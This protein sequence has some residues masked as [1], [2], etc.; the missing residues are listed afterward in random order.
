MSARRVDPVRPD[1]SEDDIAEV[2]AAVAAALRSGQLAQGAQVEAFEAEMA[3]LVDSRHAVAVASGTA[4]LVC[5]LRSLSDGARGEVL[6]PANAFYSSAAAPLLAGLDTRLAEIDLDTLAPTLATLEA[7]ATERTVGVL[8]V[9]MGGII[10]PEVT[11]IAEWCDRHGLWLVEDCAHAH[12]SRLGGR[13][14]GRFGVAGAFSFF[15][16]KVITSGEGGMVVTDDDELAHLVRLHRNLGKPEPWRSVHTVLG[17]N[18]RMS[19]LHAAVGRTQL[20]RLGEFVETRT[21]LA[22][23][24]TKA[25]QG[26][27]GVRPLLPPHDPA[28]WYKYVL[29]LDPA[30]DRAALSAELE[31]RGVRLGGAIY[32]IPLHHQPVLRGWLPAGRYPVAEAACARH[33]CLPLHTR[34]TDDDVDF[35]VAALAQ[36][37]EA[38]AVPEGEGDADVVR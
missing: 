33:V 9:H 35:V 23:R 3:E 25:L 16:T 29:L 32:E 6:V 21:R 12:G 1:F 34:M 20:R 5:V 11:A 8:L 15:A 10:T 26:I 38:V 19:E 18:A 7:A 22:R 36:V 37:M 13:H 28:S 30:V 24:Y 14:A 31:R 2:Q 17:E 27:P 4:A